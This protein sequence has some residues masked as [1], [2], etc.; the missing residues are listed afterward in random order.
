MNAGPRP[1][2]AALAH[3]LGSEFASH[4]MQH[5][6]DDSFVSENYE[7][8]RQAHVFSLGIPAELGGG[9]AS[10]PELCELLRVLGSYCGSTALALSMHT[11]LVAATVWRWRH[12]DSNAETLLRKIADKEL[13]L[14]STG[15]SD[16]VAGSGKAEAVQGGYLITARKIFGSG[17]PAGDLL[18][19]MAVYEDPAAGPTVL[20]FAVP[21]HDEHVK[22]QDNW[23]AMGMRG[24]GSNDILI[25][26]FFVPDSAISLRRPAGQWHRFRDIITPLVGPLVMSA[27]LG[28]AESARSTVLK[29]A[30]MKKD[31]A[32]M[33]LQVGEME[34]HM[35]FAQLAHEGLVALAHDYDYEPTLDRSNRTFMYKTLLTRNVLAV[36]QEAMEI[37]GGSS[38]FRDKG[39]ER[40]FRDVEA[41]QFHPLQEKKQYM[42]S[43][44]LALDLNPVS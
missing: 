3:E 2:I 26:G 42:F 23:H 13:I 40:L 24:T 21:L 38:F 25:E 29:Y 5:D 22:I 17:A 44:R 35:S 6:A 28:V 33:Q 31:D 14:V 27:Y 12:G 39:L 41:A 4:V 19:T 30:Q 37:M 10:F 11:H 15:G 1:D 18:L 43:G 32:I 9:G 16:W 7:R 20:H 8:L 36:V 34:T